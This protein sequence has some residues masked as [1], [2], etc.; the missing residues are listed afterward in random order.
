[1]PFLG[2]VYTLEDVNWLAQGY[3]YCVSGLFNL[4]ISVGGE[5]RD[6]ESDLS[7]TTPLVQ[8]VY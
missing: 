5:C 4:E 3:K 2:G 7:Y 1:M 8:S 6:Q